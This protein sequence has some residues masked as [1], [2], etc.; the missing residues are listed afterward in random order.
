MRPVLFDA[1]PLLCWFQ[2]EPGHT[3]VG[4]LFNEAEENKIE[5]FMNIINL[6]EVFYR[7]CRLINLQKAEDI[8]KKV[9]LL[10]I[11][12]VSA[13]DTLV[14]EA[15]RIK[16]KFPISYADAFAVATALQKKAVVVTRDP[17]YQSVSNLIKILWLK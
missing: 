16:G 6:G 12:I 3:I 11:S 15:A 9:R 10:P 5:I 13:S 7:T 14:L 4:G 8:L 17:E 2:E 1:F